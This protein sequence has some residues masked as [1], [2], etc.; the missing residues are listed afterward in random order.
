MYVVFVWICLT[1][2]GRAGNSWQ[3]E[4]ENRNLM[5]EST[6]FLTKDHKRSPKNTVIPCFFISHRIHVRIYVI[7]T[8]RYH[9]NHLNA[10]KYAIHGSYGFGRSWFPK[11]LRCHD[12]Q[13]QLPR[14][15]RTSDNTGTSLLARSLGWS[16]CCRHRGDWRGEPIF[17]GR[18]DQIQLY[19]CV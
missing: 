12:Q 9:K 4:E 14:A 2:G 3:G 16:V 5:P 18:D 8:Y 1:D 19:W 13:R 11:P 7:F 15:S 10:G 6:K 17:C